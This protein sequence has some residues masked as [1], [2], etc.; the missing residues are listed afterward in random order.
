MVPDVAT[1][2]QLVFLTPEA[3]RELTSWRRPIVLARR[4]PDAPVAEGVAPHHRDLGLML[5]YSPL[6]HLLL[7]RSSSPSCHDQWQP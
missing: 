6:H 1:A 5:P 7:F 2:H 4:R 3:E